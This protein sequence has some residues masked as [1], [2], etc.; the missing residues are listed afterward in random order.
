MKAW[1]DGQIVEESDTKVSLLSHSFSR[2]SAIFEVVDIVS[3]INGPALFG[4]KEHV[5]RFYNTAKLTYMDIPYDREQ[6]IQSVVETAK[7][8]RVQSG[9]AKFYAYYP[10]IEL[11]IIPSNPT[12]SLTIFAIDFDEFGLKREELSAPITVGFSRHRKNHPESVP[13]H[14]KIVGN[15]VNSFLSTMEVKKR[16]YQE[17]LLL[18][19]MGF[20]AEG[21]SSN[22]FFV[23]NR[24][25]MT[26]PLRAVLP[27]ITRSAAI[28]A[29]REMKYIVEE[30]D[31]RP[32]DILDCD[33]AFY[34]SSVAGIHPV[35]SLEGRKIGDVCPG[36]VT[37]VLTNKMK[38][39]SE[40]NLDA[41][42]KWLTYIR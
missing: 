34:T 29:L 18:D 30:I 10:N 26:P 5:D 25:V 1:L 7:V 32:D 11:K 21:P 37:T 6:L 23:K 40:G 9:A 35:R 3:T 42:N 38:E 27:G 12:L 14:A 17:A 19:T 2:G 4:L 41:F 28:Q 36:P 13:P 39:I 22:V 8:N 15:Y 20:V 31:I 33:E 24:K 16:G